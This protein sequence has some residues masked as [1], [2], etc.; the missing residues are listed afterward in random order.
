MEDV[1]GGSRREGTPRGLTAQKGA[2]EAAASKA[3]T[4][5]PA[6]R[7]PRA[8]PPSSLASSSSVGWCKSTSPGA[9]QLPP[10]LLLGQQT[11]R[12]AQ[13]KGRPSRPVGVAGGPRLQMQEAGLG[14][15]WAQRQMNSPAWPGSAR[16]TGH[17]DSRREVVT[18]LRK[19][20]EVC[21]W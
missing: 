15:E 4:P 2:C 10:R 19:D 17:G 1:P 16:W 6:G 12:E 11:H 9:L 13:G 3:L 21:P 5:G 14:A 8:G 20:Q 7:G 18:R